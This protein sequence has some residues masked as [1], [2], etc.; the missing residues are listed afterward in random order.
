MIRRILQMTA[1]IAVLA[2]AAA[3]IQAQPTT[4]TAVPQEPETPK[5]I[6]IDREAGLIDLAAKMVPVE[7]QWLELIA[8][9]PGPKGREHEAIVT[10]D[11]KPSRIHLALVTL[12]LEPGTPQNNRRE[13]DKI[14][15]EPPT[16]PTVNLFF[17]YEKDGQT[18]EVPAHKWVINQKSGETIPPCQWLFTGS[19]FRTWQDREYYMADEAGTIVSLVNFGDDLIVRQTDTTKDTDFQQLQINKEAIPPYGSDLILRIRIPPPPPEA[20]PI[21]EATQ[22]DTPDPATTTPDQPAKSPAD[23]DSSDKQAPAEP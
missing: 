16:G 15:T 11:A 4:Q 22:I 20:N 23:A 18:L 13:D 1:P 17:V 19:V 21:P 3:L 8:T 5:V 14:I 6:T 12:G 7:P 2:L 10:I 9:T